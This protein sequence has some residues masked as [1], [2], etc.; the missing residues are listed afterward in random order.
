MDFESL[1]RTT[2]LATPRTKTAPHQR[3]YRVKLYVLPLPVKE[4]TDNI[5][6]SSSKPPNRF[7]KTIHRRARRHSSRND[8]RSLTCID[9]LLI[10]RF[11]C[12]Y[13][14]IVGLAGLYSCVVKG[15][16]R[17]HESTDLRVWP[18]RDDPVVHVGP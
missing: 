8:R 10:A 4:K 7:V 6:P 2:G 11:D 13:N 12:R 16:A 3:A 15:C 9:D 14:P 18:T 17:A 1:S 5:S